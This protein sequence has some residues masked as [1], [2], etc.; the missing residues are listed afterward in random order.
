MVAHGKASPNEDW[1][2]Y[3]RAVQNVT[4]ELA[5]PYGLVSKWGKAEWTVPYSAP[6]LERVNDGPFFLVSLFNATIDIPGPFWVGKYAFTDFHGIVSKKPDW[7][8]G[9]LFDIAALAEMME[10]R[11]KVLGKDNEF[12]FDL[13]TINGQPWVHWFDIWEVVAPGA[14]TAFKHYERYTRPLTDDLYLDVAIDLSQANVAA[15]K[16][17]LPGAES[18]RERIKNSLVIRYP[19]DAST[20]DKPAEPSH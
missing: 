5:V 18:L 20:T 19:V 3:R 16:K 6:R 8:K 17:W 12:Q 11:V 9:D 4:V 13:V 10:H 15:A 7:F 2:N 14:K 1:K